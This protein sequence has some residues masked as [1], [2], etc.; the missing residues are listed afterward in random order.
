VGVR[1]GTWYYEVIVGRGDGVRGSGSGTGGD[2]GNAHVRFGWGRR[3]ANLD[4]PVGTDGYGYAIRDVGGEKVHIS[5]PKPYGRSFKSGDVI[6][7]LISLPQRQID[8]E[9]IKRKRT[10][11][12]YKGALY[13]EMDEYGIQKEMD[14]LV[15]REGKVAAAAKAAAETAKEDDKSK[16]KKK[17]RKEEDD[18]PAARDLPILPGSRVEFYLNGEPLGTAFEDLYDFLPLAPTPNPNAKKADT[19]LHDDGTLGYYPMIS[20]FG[21]GKVQC[22]FGPDWRYP[23]HSSAR[24]MSERFDEFRTE[25]LPLDERDEARDA[26]RLQKEMEEYERKRAAAELRAST[27][28]RKK[29]AVKKKRKDTETPISTPGP[30]DVKSEV[31]SMGFSRAGTEEAMKHEDVKM[32]EGEAEADAECITLIVADATDPEEGVQW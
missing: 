28:M 16:V 29:A 25:E 15:D 13:F 17:K 31:G 9:T 23:P 27:T 4:A 12:R 6:G 22:N 8:P 2:H 24:P 14:A 21:R 20:C 5:R 10:A 7:C 26:I 18:V 3:E 11:I 30:E 19:I 32:E 1:Q